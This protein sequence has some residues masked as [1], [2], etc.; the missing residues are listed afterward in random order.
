[1]WGEQRKTQQMAQYRSDRVAKAALGGSPAPG[2][3][4]SL[5]QRQVRGGAPLLQVQRAIQC[6]AQGLIS[7]SV[8]SL[9]RL[10]TSRMS[11]FF[12]AMQPSV[13]SRVWKNHSGYSSSSGVP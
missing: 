4:V 6:L 1:M 13:Q 9:T 12:M 3:S 5:A 2:R 7:I 10:H 8:P 11:S